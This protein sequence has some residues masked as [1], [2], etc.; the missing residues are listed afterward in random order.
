MSSRDAGLA[1]LEEAL[2]HHFA[3][4]SLLKRALTH[5]SMGAEKSNE[6][7]EFLG[8]RVLGLVVAERL[9]TDFPGEAEGGLAVRLNALVRRDACA[10][11]AEAVGLPDHLV[12]AKSETAGGGR[13]RPLLLAGACE[14]VIA[15][16]YLDGGFEA[17]RRFILKYWDAEFASL[18]PDLRDAKSALQE[19]SQ[20][21]KGPRA[22]PNYRI[23]ER[24]G[25]DH[26]PSFK[27]EV[28]I[29]KLD[30][31]VGEGATKRDAEQ[32]AARRMLTHLGVWPA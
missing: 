2:G 21:P 3:D 6:R 22:I 25:P 32:D 10:R 12:M 26:A 29:G 8:D 14:A 28:K 15:A 9:Y 19:W 4:R 16:L 13:K 1:A 18:A 11:V 17:T 30:P 20:G 23:A 27:V 24:E 5:A 7:L 31:V